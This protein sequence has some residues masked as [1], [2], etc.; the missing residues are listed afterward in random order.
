MPA[1]ILISGV[2]DKKDFFIE[3][4]NNTNYD[5]DI[6]G[7]ILA[8]DAKSFTI[9][10]NTIIGSKKKIIISAKVTNFSI[11]DKNTLRL[12]TSQKEVIFNY[13]SSIDSI[14]RQDLT[15][16]T[17]PIPIQ[18]S[19]LNLDENV[20]NSAIAENL[21]KN[22]NLSILPIGITASAISSDVIN[23]NQI[24]NS[25]KIIIFIV[26]LIFIGISASAVYFIRQKKIVSSAGDDFKILDE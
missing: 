1:D 7:W 16:K 8:S 4:L 17:I 15:I 23:N 21:T 5:I 13:P 18:T 6:S 24:N 14:V 22:L 11:E 10:R 20:K 26:F 12:M 3:L 2:G 25:Q 9:P 19:R